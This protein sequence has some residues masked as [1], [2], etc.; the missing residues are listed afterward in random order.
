MGGIGAG[1]HTLPSTLFALSQS[2]AQKVA[3]KTTYPRASSV[4]A[5][6]SLGWH[7]DTSQ[8]LVD[9]REGVFGKYDTPRLP[10]RSL[11]DK[12]D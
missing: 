9:L 10:E 7:G 4:P 2:M 3:F 12:T 6:Q 1:G 5:T 8:Q 11:R